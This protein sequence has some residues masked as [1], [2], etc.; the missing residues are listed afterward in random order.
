MFVSALLGGR[1]KLWAGLLLVAMFALGSRAQNPSL[2]NCIDRPTV[3]YGELYAD[4]TRWCVESVLH[5]PDMEPLAFTAL[6]TAPDGSLFAARPLAGEVM[7]IQDSDGDSLPDAMRTYAAG[8]SLPNGLAYHAGALYV[9][10]G[11]HVYRISAEGAIDILVDDLPVGGGFASGGLAIGADERLYL[12]M[13]APC[14]LCEHPESERG[15]ILSMNLDGGDR[16]VF[17]SGFRNPAD[18]AFFRGQ[19][20]S[21]DS[22]PNQSVGKALDELNRL[23]AGGFY[24]FPYCLGR[25][26]SGLDSQRRV[27]ESSIAP[28]MQ[29]GSGAM[30]SSL[31]AYEHD[32]LPGTEDT[33]IVVLKGEPSQVDIVGYKVIMISFDDDDQ[34]IGAVVLLPYRFEGGRLAFQAYDAQGL[35][36]KHFIHINEMGV[37]FFP[38]RPL[39]VAVSPR[40]WIYISITGG[41]IIALR[42]R[43]K[44]QG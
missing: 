20:W 3:V 23:E 21:L 34:P 8:L 41:R 12:A 38:Q 6:E 44:Q 26:A 22:G 13:G 29:F 15:A 1:G 5:D 16:Q 37:G 35:F 24:G 43:N 32:L 40:G 42:P 28:V 2:P 11:A 14:S 17:A 19:L 39:A 27:C 33:L 4:N 18:I 7:V 30:P 9:A 25:A 36:W 31:A 10:G